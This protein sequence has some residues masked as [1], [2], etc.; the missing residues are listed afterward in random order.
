MT[1]IDAQ[2]FYKVRGFL[3]IPILPIMPI[4]AA[5]QLTTADVRTDPGWW[6]L[7]TESWR[8]IQNCLHIF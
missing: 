1:V 3:L 7:I 2:P 4:L 6:N 5:S 8:I